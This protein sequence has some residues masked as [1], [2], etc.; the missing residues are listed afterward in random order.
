M[1]TGKLLFRYQLFSTIVLF[2]FYFRPLPTHVILDR[3]QSALGKQGYNLL[4]SNCEH[5]ATD[6]RYGQA[7]CRQVRR[8]FTYQ[9][10]KKI[11]LIIFRCK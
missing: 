10:K 4:Y 6:C 11:K 9:R 8:L 7:N 5:F 3:A 2:P 1:S